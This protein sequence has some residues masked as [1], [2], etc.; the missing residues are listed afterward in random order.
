MPL[1]EMTLPIASVCLPL[2]PIGKLLNILKELLHN[3][4]IL[5]INL[6]L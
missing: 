1:S 4:E 5:E 6:K 2:H 3:N